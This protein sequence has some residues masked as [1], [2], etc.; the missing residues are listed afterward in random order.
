V[1]LYCVEADNEMFLFRADGGGQRRITGPGN[2]LNYTNYEWDADGRSFIYLRG[3]SFGASA[4]PDALLQGMV[5]YDI[6][7]GLSS[8]VLPFRVV[9]VAVNDVL[10]IRSGP[11]ADNPVVGEMPF[12]GT[13]FV[14]WRW[15]C[16][17]GVR[18][19]PIVY[20]STEGWVN[21]QYLV[22]EV[23]S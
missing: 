14:D 22:E 10:N 12:D 9:E 8:M 16:G 5:R 17:D 2:R 6:E 1:I 3:Y 23:S 11:G 13:V 21:S 18:W 20:G 15:C 4:P 19:V 7:T